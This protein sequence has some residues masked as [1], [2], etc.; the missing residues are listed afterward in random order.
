MGRII[1]EEHEDPEKISETI[2]EMEGLVPD[3]EK[4]VIE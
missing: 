2:N 4:Y 1:N 3:Q